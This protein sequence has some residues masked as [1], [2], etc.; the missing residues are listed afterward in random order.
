M[1]PTLA[2]QVAGRLRE[3][4]A[5]T[6]APNGTPWSAPSNSLRQL[7]DAIKAHN[8]G[9]GPSYETLRVLLDGRTAKPRAAVLLPIARFFG[10]TVAELGVAPDPATELLELAERIPQLR[11]IA[12]ALADLGEQ[13]VANFELMIVE[14]S[15]SAREAETAPAADAP[16]APKG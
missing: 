12:L 7:A 3:L 5:T 6:L 15:M 1:A 13:D 8:G 9:T 11:R 4:L 16:S 10:T 2:Q 14:A